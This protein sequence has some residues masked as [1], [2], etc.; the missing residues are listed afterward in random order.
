MCPVGVE[1]RRDL[2]ERSAGE[3]SLISVFKPWL[4]EI[5]LKN[6]RK[7]SKKVRDSSVRAENWLALADFL[8]GFTVTSLVAPVV[9]KFLK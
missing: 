2:L 8:S 4:A 1:G 9:L 7:L 5:C 3:L 6:P